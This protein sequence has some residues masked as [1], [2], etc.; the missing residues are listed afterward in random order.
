MAAGAVSFRYVVLGLLMLQPMSGYDIKRLLA[1]LSWL[2]GSPSGGSLY[3][4]LRTLRQDELVTVE[5]VGGLDKPPKKVYSITEAGHQALHAWTSQ[6]V[7]TCASLR[8]F[9]MR[10]FLAGSHSRAGLSAHLRE[11]RDQVASHH[12][13]LADDLQTPSAGLG[14]QL[15][16]DYG[17]AL[18][19]AE[20]AW[21]D[22]ILE[23]LPQE[24]L[25][26][27]DHQSSNAVIQ[28]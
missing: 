22:A 23:R 4:V 5:T 27:G 28:L 10:L 6:P 3:P 17:L 2:A 14:Q 16:V 19:T 24:P 8:A 26:E 12:Q 18:A 1:G 9:L 20:L 25:L 11:R 21:L 13:L 7:A 15:A